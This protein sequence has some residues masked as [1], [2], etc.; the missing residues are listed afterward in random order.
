MRL[1]LAIL[2][3]AQPVMAASFNERLPEGNGLS[4]ARPATARSRSPSAKHGQ[5]HDRQRAVKLMMWGAPAFKVG[6]EVVTLTM[7]LLVMK[8]L[9]GA[10][11]VAGLLIIYQLAQAAGRALTPALLRRFP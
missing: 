10:T 9:G 1:L 4:V 3:A 11:F 8:N 6:A 5:R 2:L 7:P